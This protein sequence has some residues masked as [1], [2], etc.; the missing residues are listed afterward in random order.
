ML[1][2]CKDSGKIPDNF[3]YGK[4]ENGV[5]RNDFF[6]FQ[7][8]VPA[9]WSI[10]NKEQTEEIRK[11]GRQM[12]EDANKDFADKISASDVRSATLLTVFKYPVDSAAME[13]N[14]SFMIV[15]ENMAGAK[16]IK[17]GQDYLEQAKKLMFQSNMG[18]RVTP[19]FT[20][21]KIDNRE[22][23]VME[24]VNNYGGQEDVK[25]LYYATIDKGFA[26]VTI[27]SFATEEQ[28]AELKKTLGQIKF[29]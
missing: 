26:L 14:P 17:R 23:D 29:D 12:M 27:I 16:G 21:E 13:F 15:S 24:T 20:K 11:R 6:K 1:I 25:Q 4:T 19:G 8:P 7:V 22:F 3:D 5:Y 10:Q 2:G 9:D 28:E 18:Y